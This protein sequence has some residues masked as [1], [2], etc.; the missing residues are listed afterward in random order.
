MDISPKTL[1]LVGGGCALSFLT[2]ATSA[3]FATNQAIKKKYEKISNEEIASVKEYYKKDRA[4][5]VEQKVAS[6]QAIMQE[7]YGPTPTETAIEFLEEAPV[8]SENIFRTDEVE[9]FQVDDRDESIPH[10]I[11]VDEFMNGTAD[12]DQSTLAYFEMDDVLVDERDQAIQDE[13][14]T[15]GENNLK[16]GYGSNDRNCVYIR[17]PRLEMDFEVI[18]SPGSYTQEV[19]GFI[20]HSDS[21]PRKFRGGYE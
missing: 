13:E 10:I 2:G 21:T 1:L 18:R 6:A 19:L 20:E 4:E 16:F 3:Y 12:F 17:N 5:I 11:T 9:E 7:K 14:G 8:I 15:I